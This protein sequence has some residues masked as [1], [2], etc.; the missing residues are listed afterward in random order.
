M[1]HLNQH[2]KDSSSRMSPRCHLDI[3]V[4]WFSEVGEPLVGFDRG[5]NLSLSALG[6]DEHAN[7]Q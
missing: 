7:L 6:E 1:H 4:G 5:K 2:T 3:L